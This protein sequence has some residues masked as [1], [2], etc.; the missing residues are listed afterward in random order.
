MPLQ[1]GTP[2]TPQFPPQSAD[3]RSLYRR[4]R[5]LAGITLRVTVRSA[6]R[7]TPL[8]FDRAHG[9]DTTDELGLHDRTVP[10]HD[11]DGR[12]RYEPTTPTHFRF[13]MGQVPAPLERWAF[14][15]IGSGKG[16]A[17]MLAMAYPFRR[18]EGV[19]LDPALHRV[20]Q[21]NL[22]RYRGPRRCGQVAVHC[23]DATTAPLP[24]GDVV[25]F[26]YNSLSGELLERFLDHL[27]ASAREAPRRILLVYSSPMRRA[28]VERRPAFRIVFDGH[29][30][31][32]LVWKSPRRLI[33]YDVATGAGAQPAVRRDA[34][35]GTPAPEHLH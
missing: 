16:R 30:P 35:A 22:R 27:E 11:R 18:V 2:A 13:A 26:F 14:V 5:R 6:L 23:G 34:A 19:E 10:L 12:G 9:V 32:D 33:F 24:P 31:S 21:E 4:L 8:D 7:Y 29:S 1:P 25:V 3:D 28:A 17:V 20:A 15:D